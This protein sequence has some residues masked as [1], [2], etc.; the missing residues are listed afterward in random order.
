MDESVTSEI[1]K[2]FE[3][4]CF[5]PFRTRPTL[6]LSF[7]TMRLILNESC[8]TCKNHSRN[9]FGMFVINI[10]VFFVKCLCTCHVG[11][12]N[13]RTKCTIS[14]LPRRLTE[15]NELKYLSLETAISNQ[16]FNFSN[17]ESF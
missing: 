12:E 14:K 3:T 4:F 7:R 10:F 1:L 2:R 5:V 6:H 16:R 8:F 13:P 11:E 9:D 15:M 17:F